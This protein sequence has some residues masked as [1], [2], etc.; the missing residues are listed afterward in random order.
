MENEEFERLEA[1]QNLVEENHSLITQDDLKWMI[2]TLRVQD[3]MLNLMATKITTP[4][5]GKE[6]VLK[7]F[8]EEAESRLCGR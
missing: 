6:W 4:I 3:T 8:K 1:I 5:N 2:H 7:Y